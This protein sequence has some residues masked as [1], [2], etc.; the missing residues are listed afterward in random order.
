MNI[1]RPNLIPGYPHF[2][3]GGDYNPDQWLKSPEVIDEDF[4]LMPL[5][6]CNMFSVGIFAWT[7]YEPSEGKYRFD[8]LDS[9]MDRMAAA[10]NRV[11]L[12]TPSG[13]KPAWLSQK[14][15]EIR[16]VNRQGLREPYSDR[17]N[18][19]WTSPV[20]REKVHSINEQL[21]TRYKGHPALGMWHLSNEYGGTCYCD[22]CLASFH[23]WLEDRYKTLDALN[24]AWWTGFWSHTYTDFSQINPRDDAVDGLLVDWLRFHNWQLIDFM[25]AEMVP[26]RAI[27][28]DVPCTTN[29]MG[30]HYE[31]WYS[32][33]G[34]HIDLIA[35]DQ[36]P[37][38]DGDSPN[39]VRDAVGI[40]FKDDLYRNILPG[41]PWMLMESCPESPQW[42][43]PMRIKQPG[44]HLAEMIQA[45]AH[46]AEGTC[47]FQWR[48]GRGGM[49][50]LHGAVV[51]HVQHE[52]TRAFQGVAE[53]GAALK[54]I[55]PALGSTVQAEVAFLFDWES[56]WA[57][58]S[59][60]GPDIVGWGSGVNYE[61]GVIDHYQ[62]F[63]ELGVPVD[64]LRPEDAFEKYRVVVAP[65]LF[66]MHPGFAERVRAYVADGGTVVFDLFSGIVDSTNRCFLGGWPGDGLRGVFGVWLEEFDGLH[67][68]QTKQCLS[69]GAMLPSAFSARHHCGI[70]HLE[71]AEALGTYGE[72]FYAGHP[73][74]TR[75]R[76]G[77]GNAFYWAAHVEVDAYRSFYAALVA[78]LGIAGTLPEAPPLGV[79]AS[80]RSGSE[81]EFLFLINFSGESQAVAV[82]EG[83]SSLVGPAPV[84]GTANLARFETAVLRR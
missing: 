20:Y 63:W 13:A 9:I 2:L 84:E 69:E 7:T 60:N 59:T 17:H 67:K 65:R 80:K 45:V 68:G 16:R 35:D 72:S 83:W 58:G 15:P 41:K 56:R 27:T 31:N 33:I 26:L 51:D 77:S 25:K 82:G 32:E 5:A 40:S 55:E 21:A 39:L 22:L 42:R 36:Y 6:G 37:A 11:V 19:C 66:M 64:V 79:L 54:T 47:Y 28:P 14:Y 4:R 75:H 78:E 81:G 70:V 50:K 38:Y 46:G 74:A 3:H 52:N 76:F 24:D 44:L 62:A 29:F 12:A 30:L 18:H 8:W 43:H 73:V 10:G 48:K 34:K 1:A 53:V 57:L 61:E 23:A 71:G 49:E